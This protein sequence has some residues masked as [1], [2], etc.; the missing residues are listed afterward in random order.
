MTILFYRPISDTGM[1]AAAKLR[2]PY[3]VEAGYKAET[4]ED[5]TIGHHLEPPSQE[6]KSTPSVLVCSP[7]P[8]DLL[9]KLLKKK[10]N[11]PLVIINLGPN[12]SNLNRLFFVLQK[13]GYYDPLLLTGL[14]SHL[15]GYNYMENRRVIIASFGG[16]SLTIEPIHIPI[17]VPFTP[18]SSICRTHKSP[19]L[20][21]EAGPRGWYQHGIYAGGRV[22]VSLAEGNSYIRAEKLN[23]TYGTV[24]YAIDQKCHKLA[25]TEVT[26]LTGYPLDAEIRLQQLLPQ[27][28][29]FLIYTLLRDL[30]Y[31]VW[32][33]LFERII[34]AQRQQLK[35]KG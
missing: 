13:H 29:G 9:D 2:L 21:L 3:Y 26:R 5:L 14:S 11:P 34:Y 7:I 1:L 31:P 27:E 24:R 15:L 8:V 23:P 17:A 12:P 28:N 16:E 25:L 22:Y 32:K 20:K 4:L 35:Q 33:N 30:S 18:L 19:P 10:R 6:I